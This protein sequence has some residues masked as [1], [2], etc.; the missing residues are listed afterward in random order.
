[1]SQKLAKVG[2]E[3]FVGPIEHSLLDALNSAWD[4]GMSRNGCN[5]KIIFQKVSGYDHLS[6]PCT[7][8]DYMWFWGAEF[9][10]GAGKLMLLFP[11]S[12]DWDKKDGSQMDRSIGIYTKGD[13]DDDA[14]STVLVQIIRVLEKPSR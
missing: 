9:E 14:L 2:L 4:N 10:V 13:V 3:R 12:Q 11:W 6:R 8:D 5:L 1:M 7:S